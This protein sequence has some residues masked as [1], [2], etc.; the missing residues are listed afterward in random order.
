MREGEEDRFDINRGGWLFTI[1]RRTI[2][3][4]LNRGLMTLHQA[5]GEPGEIQDYPRFTR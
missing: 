1:R 4:V 2:A 5:E 3:V